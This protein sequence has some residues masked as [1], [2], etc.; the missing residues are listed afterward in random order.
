[1][2]H[3]LQTKTDAHITALQHTTGTTFFTT[4]CTAQTPKQ[5]NNA[6]PSHLVVMRRCW[7]PQACRLDGFSVAMQE[8]ICVSGARLS[9]C[10][11]SDHPS[12]RADT[13]CQIRLQ[14]RSSVSA[15]MNHFATVK[16]KTAGRAVAL[17]SPIPFRVGRVIAPLHS[18][19][20]SVAMLLTASLLQNMPPTHL[21]TTLADSI[22]IFLQ[23]SLSKCWDPLYRR[24]IRAL[25]RRVCYGS[26]FSVKL[27]A[28]AEYP[29]VF[30]WPLSALI[31]I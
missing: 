15:Q 24:S 4:Q 26:S 20:S 6:N 14:L 23:L 30:F 27:A 11:S 16:K 7:L 21:A 12:Q 13:S 29:I 3:Q 5:L 31:A 19:T 28:A 10:E 2:P 18:L 25:A 8:Q 9:I 17:S 22:D 1:M